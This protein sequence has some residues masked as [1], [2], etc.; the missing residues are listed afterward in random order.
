M[1]V[2]QN[3]NNIR[4][5]VEE[6]WNK[7]KLDVIPELISPN[8]RNRS[9]QNEFKGPEG[10]KQMVTSARTAFPDLHFTIDEMVGE[11]DTLAV[12]YTYTGTFKGEYMG[13]APT[14]KKATMTVAIFHRFE[15]G[16]QVGAQSFSDM[17]SFYQQW[18]I[19]IPAP[20]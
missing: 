19:P 7:G 6:V 4:R 9:G 11:G 5:H 16:K 17:L 12:R 20:R 15:K 18:G 1:S 8:Y 13:I 2:E 10:F 3:K 14:G